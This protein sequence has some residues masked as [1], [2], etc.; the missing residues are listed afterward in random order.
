MDDYPKN[1]HRSRSR[2]LVGGSMTAY[3][4]DFYVGYVAYQRGD[5]ATALLIFRQLADQGDT[6][7]QN[8]L[9]VMYENGQ[10]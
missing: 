7:A 5:Y 10:G 8:T 4:G 1:C 6:N 2:Y 3:V 9:G